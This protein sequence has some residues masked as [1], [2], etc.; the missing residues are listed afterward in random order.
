MITADKPNSKPFEANENA[1]TSICVENATSID[2][3]HSKLKYIRRWSRSDFGYDSNSDT[4]DSSNNNSSRQITNIVTRQNPELLIDYKRFIQTNYNLL[5]VI[6]FVKCVD[7]CDEI[8]SNISFEET[9]SDIDDD[10]N[11]DDKETG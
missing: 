1:T 6:T 5:E 4:S 2:Q 10:E 7:M 11:L 3:A 8:I 9:A